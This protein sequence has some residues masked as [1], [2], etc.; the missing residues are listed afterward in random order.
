MHCHIERHLSWGMDMTFIVKNGSNPEA[1][2][3]PPPSDLPP[4]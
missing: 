2:L 3:L 4:C 1:Q